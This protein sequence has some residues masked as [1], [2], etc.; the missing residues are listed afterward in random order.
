MENHVSE[1][2][3]PLFGG[4]PF[5]PDG[6]DLLTLHLPRWGG[7][8]LVNFVGVEN[9]FGDIVHGILL[10]PATYDGQQI[11]A[12]SQLA[13]LDELVDVFQKG[14]WCTSTLRRKRPS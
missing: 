5:F 2:M 7:P 11:Q 4:F 6:D 1:A 9:D 12:V 8:G 13:T 10:E 14:A 3:A